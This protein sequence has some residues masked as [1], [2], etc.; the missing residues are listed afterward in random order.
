MRKKKRGKRISVVGIIFSLVAIV[1][2]GFA[3]TI[4]YQKYSGTKVTER[5]EDYFGIHSG[6][7]TALVVD[8]KKLE[9]KGRLIDGQPY[10]D[11]QT[12]FDSINSGFY[13][14]TASKTLYITL[15]GGTSTFKPEDGSG[16]VVMDGDTP[17]IS[18]DCIKNNSDVEAKVY[19]APSRVVVRTEFKSVKTATVNADTVLRIKGGPKSNVLTELS[20]GETITIGKQFD[21]WS[22][23]ATEDGYVGYVKNSDITILDEPGIAH[24]TDEKFKFKR[25]TFSNG[26]VNM[27]WQTV[28]STAAN[29]NMAALTQNASG[30]NVIS[31]TWFRLQD[32]NGTL[33][34]F[35]DKAYVDAAHAK[36]YQVWALLGAFGSDRIDIAEVLKTS[37]A[38]SNI[39]S[40]LLQAAEQTGLDGINIDIESIGEGEA[41]Q[42]LQF[43]R[44]LS[45]A[46]HEKNLILSVDNY[47]PLY[48]KHVKRKEQ[49]KFVDYLI[50]MGYDE[51]TNGSKE[52]GSV[53]SLPFVEKGIQDTLAEVDASQVI[54]AVPFYTRGWTEAFGTDAPASEALGM[55]QADQWAAQKGIQTAYDSSVG[56]N[57][58]TADGTD[59][60]Y[61]IWLEDETALKNKMELIE[62]YQL[63]GVAAWRLGF[64]RP[65]VWQIIQSYLK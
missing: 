42:Y 60:T 41:P 31:P 25:M 14:E 27:A 56:E 55:D 30:L 20:D 65:T 11:Y 10:I 64:E 43:L 52:A 28:E 35:A 3:T 47:V 1:A 2:I 63:A 40:Q 45:I 5:P 37:Q 33:R 38:R 34:S 57:T 4:F 29:G 7:E 49:A 53:A 21:N 8:G 12:V 19:D 24:E 46:M 9:T 23:A 51:H 32:A 54:N 59:A 58:G 18:L 61:S 50:I 22:E 62:K 26:K 15:Q 6:T 13:W 36:G 16:A 17:Y 44:E 39:I 48:T